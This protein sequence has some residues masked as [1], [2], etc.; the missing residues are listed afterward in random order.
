MQ[1]KASTT[2]APIATLD[3][4]TGLP[5]RTY[6]TYLLSRECAKLGIDNIT[7]IAVEISRFGQINNNFGAKLADKVLTLTCKRIKNLFPDALCFFRSHGD[8]FCIAFNKS[9]EI[10]FELERLFDFIQRPFAIKGKVVVLTIKVGVNQVYDGFTTPEEL[11][12]ASELA[13]HRIKGKLASVNFYEK[14]M[15]QSAQEE[16]KIANDLRVVSFNQAKALYNGAENEAFHLRY[17]P[18]V[19]AS[20]N[21]LISINPSLCWVNDGSTLVTNDEFVKVAQEIGNMTLLNTWEIKHAIA[22]FSQWREEALITP[23][24]RLNL[25]INTVFFDEKEKLSTLIKS[26]L[27]KYHIQANLLCLEVNETSEFL[28]N[29]ISE[30]ATLQSIGCQICLNDFGKG[31]YSIQTLNSLPLNLVKICGKFINDLDSD[32]SN[33]Q[34]LAHKSTS[35]VFS[36]ARSL[37]LDA[38]VTGV[39]TKIQ[40]KLISDFKANAYQ[41]ALFTKALKSDDFRKYL[42]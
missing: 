32:N 7:V 28:E 31:N 39:N 38:I 11:I 13:L 20:K 6:G 25:N 33:D 5:D 1:A 10:A 17:Q 36:L 34:A 3:P 24:V 4:L 41:G 22:Q 2:S 18:I 37:G 19:D 8:Q 35:V 16:H 27:E 21:K 12:N 14:H 42:S 26:Q 15:V 23:E 40:L 30:L 9:N 29:M